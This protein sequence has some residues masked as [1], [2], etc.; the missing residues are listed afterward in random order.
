V[1]AFAERA[2]A[3]GDGELAQ[4]MRQLR[5]SGAFRPQTLHH[6]GPKLSVRPRARRQQL[7]AYAGKRFVRAA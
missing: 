6:D 1:R 5:E 4:A 3:V 2:D 7:I